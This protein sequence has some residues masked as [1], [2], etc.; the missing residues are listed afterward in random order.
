VEV[1]TFKINPDVKG[2]YD[3][4][5]E[6]MMKSLVERLLDGK[7]FSSVVRVSDKQS[8][9]SSTTG[10]VLE[11][12]VTKFDRSNAAKI[13]TLGIDPTQTILK[14]TYKVTDKATGKVLVQKE[15]KSQGAKGGLAG[16]ALK[17]WAEVHFQMA[18]LIAGKVNK[19]AR[20]T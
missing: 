12:I 19:L 4:D 3:K 20:K 14:L 2:F 6:A 11:G 15:V 9:S 18:K 7:Q 17:G 8:V 1:V 13:I 5:N 16:F 10:F